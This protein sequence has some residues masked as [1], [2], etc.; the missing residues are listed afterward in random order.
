MPTHPT[1][2]LTSPGYYAKKVERLPEALNSPA[3]RDEAAD[4]I[5][6]LIERVTRTPGAKR[7]EVHMTLKGSSAPSSNG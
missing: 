7:S 5:R 2:T 1:F 3:Y 6:G 4:A